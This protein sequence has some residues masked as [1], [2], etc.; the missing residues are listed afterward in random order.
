VKD[1][2]THATTRERGVLVA[3]GH[4]LC[5]SFCVYGETMKI[6]SDLIR[7]NGSWSIKPPRVSNR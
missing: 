2:A 1:M 7:V 6:R 4:G 3:M 5:V